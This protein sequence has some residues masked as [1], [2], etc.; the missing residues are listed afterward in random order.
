VRTTVTL[1]E[2][3][4][5][6]LRDV[7]RARGISFKAAI[8]EAIRAGLAEPPDARPFRVEVRPLGLRAGIDL[9]KA[10]ALAAQLEDNE[11]LRRMKRER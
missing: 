1:D 8:N 4:A 5:L 6:K 10:N 9:T 7:A 3:I 2:D 11:M